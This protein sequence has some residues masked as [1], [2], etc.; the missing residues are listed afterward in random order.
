[1]IKMML[2]SW[3]L[4]PLPF[5]SPAC[6]SGSSWLSY[7]WSLAWRILNITLLACEMSLCGSLNIL[8]HCP[9]LGL[10]WELTFFQS[11]GHCWVF[12][13]GW[14]IEC[15]TFT[16]WYLFLQAGFCRL[17]Q[18]DAVEHVPLSSIFV[19][20]NFIVRS[21][22]LIRVTC[23]HQVCFV[24]SL[25][26]VCDM[27]GYAFL[28]LTSSDTYCFN[29][30]VQLNCKASIFLYLLAGIFCEMKLSL[31]STLVKKFTLVFLYDVMEKPKQT[32][33]PT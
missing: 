10:E 31:L 13:I 5:L 26:G 22:A 23:P 12:Q 33:R 4:A 24:S 18:C 29:L 6:T 15:S 28:W 27:Y 32:L 1:M 25:R 2:A 8:W 14:H 9:S 17:Y 19:M 20:F 21:R 11:C 30:L 16:T 3:C 7:Y